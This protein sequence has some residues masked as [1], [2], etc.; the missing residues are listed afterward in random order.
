MDDFD[1]HGNPSRE[2]IYEI[3][4]EDS[5]TPKR[6]DIY[7]HPELGL[8]YWDPTD[9]QS[10]E[11]DFGGHVPAHRKPL[12]FIRRVSDLDTHDHDL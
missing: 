1:D 3:R 2:G 12:E 4:L 9:R 11:L 5:K 8:C 6:I 7:D 10:V